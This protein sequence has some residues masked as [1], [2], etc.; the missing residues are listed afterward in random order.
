MW[1]WLVDPL[2]L[3]TGTSMELKGCAFSRGKLSFPPAF[4]ATADIHAVFYDSSLQSDRAIV[5]VGDQIVGMDAIGSELVVGEGDSNVDYMHVFTYDPTVVWVDITAELKSPSGSTAPLLQAKSA[6][7]YLYIG[8]EWRQFT[9]LK[10]NVDIQYVADGGV[11]EWEYYNGVTASWEPLRVM[12]AENGDHPIVAHDHL[13]YSDRVFERPDQEQVHIDVSADWVATMVNGQN[14][15]WIRWGVSSPIGVVGTIPELERLKLGT[16]RTEINECGLITH[17]G[18]AQQR[19]GMLWHLGLAAPLSVGTPTN[20][21]VSYSA[22]VAIT[23]SI[24]KFNNNALDGFG[25]KFCVPIGLN[26]A[27][28]LEF[29]VYWF[30]EPNG[31]PSNVEL[32]MHIVRVQEGDDINSGTL[33]EALPLVG[34]ILAP[35]STLIHTVGVADANLSV[36]SRFRIDVSAYEA[37]D[38]MIFSLFRDATGGNPDD[39]LT[40]DIVIDDSFLYGYFWH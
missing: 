5:S 18:R 17:H 31:S 3:G 14:G 40:G 11:C 29:D 21:L 32:E 39:D 1:D 9:G 27:R 34:T 8:H 15:Y 24:N 36:R 37:G 2:L 23:P 25:G 22:N 20:G 19:R 6:G 35:A 38:R 12:C 26:T 33:P 10:P 13:Q 28:L 30:P 16:N 7:G 4:S